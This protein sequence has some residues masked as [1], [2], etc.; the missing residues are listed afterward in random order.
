MN[1]RIMENTVKSN[2][3]DFTIRRGEN[4]VHQLLNWIVNNEP[5]DLQNAEEVRV[6]FRM[7]PRLCGVPDLSLSVQ[8]GGVTLSGNNMDMLFN[9]NTLSLHPGI[10]YYDVLVIKNSERCNWVKGKMILENIITR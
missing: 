5:F 3:Y 9:S 4:S 10:Y 8:N 7:N 2:T 6:D 1:I